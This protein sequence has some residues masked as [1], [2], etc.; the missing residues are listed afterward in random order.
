MISSTRSQGFTLL[1]MLVVLLIAGMAMALT[2][3]AL[4]QFKKAYLRVDVSTQTGRQSRLQEKW[5]TDSASALHPAVGYRAN[6][7]LEP[8]EVLSARERTLVFEGNAQRFSGVT[9]RPVLAGQGIPTY[10][11]WSIAQDNFGRQHLQLEESGHTMSFPFNGIDRMQLAY[12]STDGSSHDTWPPSDDIVPQLP[13]AITLKLNNDVV[14]V[15][16]ITGIKDA[17]R[18]VYEPDPM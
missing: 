7:G 11:I 1:E 5:F 12:I 8:P 15:A 6:D 3:Q 9:L 2:S 4:G 17:A 18:N 10:Q 16:A 13:E 14:I